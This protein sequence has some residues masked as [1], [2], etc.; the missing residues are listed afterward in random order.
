MLDLTN[1]FLLA[2]PSQ[3]MGLFE[4]SLIYITKHHYLTGA[5]GVIIN[6]PLDRTI[7]SAF[8][9]IDFSDYNPNWGD[10][11]LYFGGPVS[12]DSGFVLYNTTDNT[13][14]RFNLTN[15][16]AILKATNL[17]S[18]D[19]KLFISIG[20][21]AWD[22]QQLETEIANG[23]WLCV[24]YTPGKIFEVEPKLR[25]KAVLNLLGISDSSYLYSSPESSIN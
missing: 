5:V 9:N 7:Q 21:V 4:N 12:L 20:Y 19:D 16:K 3:T 1:H 8:Q 2:T 14:N 18:D 24:P 25:Y 11:Q 17:F 22:A 23:L 15:K 10:S 6:R 13:D